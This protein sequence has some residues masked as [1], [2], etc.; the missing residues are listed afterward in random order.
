MQ[1]EQSPSTA[2]INDHIESGSFPRSL[3]IDLP[4]TLGGCDIA[5][6]IATA[7]LCEKKEPKGCKA[8]TACEMLSEKTHPDYLVVRSDQTETIKID[9]LRTALNTVQCSP[10]I[11]VNQ[12]LYIEQAEQMT[13]QCANALLK[14]LEEPKRGLYIIL[15]TKTTRKLIPTITSRCYV[16]RPKCDAIDSTSNMHSTTENAYAQY[17][18][19]THR[20]KPEAMSDRINSDRYEQ[21]SMLVS[22]MIGNTAWLPLEKAEQLGEYDES[23]IY[24]NIIYYLYGL[25]ATDHA[26]PE[27]HR[28]GLMEHIQGRSINRKKTSTQLTLFRLL[29]ICI[30]VLRNI[31]RGMPAS[32]HY[33]LESSLIKLWETQSQRYAN[34]NI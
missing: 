22:D 10:R 16:Y 5:A 30:H 28:N 33:R 20:Y 23:E 31:D 7:L 11:G 21:L 12:V 19:F 13:V 24:S 32:Q 29:D 6:E 18:R 27:Q 17:I 26:I 15:Q 14:T 34:N 4:K 25:L 2:F 8:C 9:Q 1:V 3:C